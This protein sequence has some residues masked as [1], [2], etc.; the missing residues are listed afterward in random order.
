MSEIALLFECFDSQNNQLIPNNVM[1]EI[2]SN[3]PDIP[4]TRHYNSKNETTTCPG[5][6]DVCSTM[7]ILRDGQE[8]YIVCDKP[9]QYGV[10]PLKYDDVLLWQLDLYELADFLAI[11]LNV[12]DQTTE[13]IKDRIYN[14]GV[15]QGKCLF[16]VKGIDWNDAESII[17]QNNITNF[18]PVLITLTP[19]PTW[20][21]MPAI[22]IGH[23]INDD[24]SINHE[25]LDIL[26]KN[27]I[28][29]EGNFLKLKGEYWH[30]CYEGKEVILQN[31]N[32]LVYLQHLLYNPYK[33]IG[34][35]VLNSLVNKQSVGTADNTKDNND[36]YSIEGTIELMDEQT[37]KEVQNR[38]AILKESNP[39]SEELKTLEKYLY[40]ATYQ[41]K[42]K[43]FKDTQTKISNTVSKAISRAID[44]LK[45]SHPQLYIHLKT[46]ITRGNDCKYTP[47][48]KISWK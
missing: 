10:I 20:L 1:V 45:D 7:P 42:I 27:D 48:N 18:N 14:I 16:L 6:E 36:S 17:L 32:G 35:I 37:K 40:E 31:T 22:W 43:T 39:E 19:I 47:E 29:L 12:S 28:T 3:L 2:Q 13:T 30:I 34:V 25:Q 8:R 15:Y 11:R 33:A 24:L 21:G 23:L 9:Q 4:F 41:G 44:S 38:I 46:C 26:I 5:C